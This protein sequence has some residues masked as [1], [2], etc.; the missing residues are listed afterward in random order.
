[1]YSVDGH[2]K[3]IADRVRVAAHR[4]ALRRTVTPGAVVVDLG[5]GT[6]IFAAAACAAGARRV[7][8]IEP[9]EVIHV[10]RD[11]AVANGYADRV[12][13]LQAEST[14]VTLPERADVV[15]SDLRGVLPP[16]GQHLASI[17]DARTRFLAP[18]GRLIPR[19]DDLL[20]A[21][22]SAPDLY[23]RHTSPWDDE[24]CGIDLSELRRLTT[25]TWHKARIEPAC[26]LTE[27]RVWAELTYATFENP[28]VCGRAAWTVA[29]PAVAHGIGAWF[30]ATLADGVQ[31]SNAPGAANLI[32][33]QALFPWPEP[34]S[35][36]A[37]DVVEVELH[38]K[39]TG[40]EYEWRWMTVATAGAEHGCV[41]A[42][43]RQSTLSALPLSAAFLH[44]T[45]PA[46]V[47]TISEEGELARFVLERMD[48]TRSQEAIASDLVDR[49]G[50]RF[51]GRSQARTF[52]SAVAVRYAR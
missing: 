36:E 33:G 48:G 23:R 51:E 14:R 50:A 24:A 12:E 41:K 13:F 8:A 21:V 45:A 6:G 10:A 9:G 28:D 49:Y 31:F 43:F 40:A 52:V 35:L 4:E 25:N 11:L 19:R 16:F 38:A 2:A 22:V 37:G 20:A 27:P 26:L 7:Y 47:C 5:T 15:V 32:Y 18:G 3:M 1:M 29:R 44:K 17:I 46:H 34:V 30:D 39:L 42:D